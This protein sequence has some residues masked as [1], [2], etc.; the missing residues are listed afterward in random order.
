MCLYKDLFPCLSGQ[1]KGVTII[2][3]KKFTPVCNIDVI[4]TRRDR[5]PF[6][7]RESRR[8]QAR[9]ITSRR[10][11]TQR[12]YDPTREPS[13][14]RSYRHCFAIHAARL[15]KLYVWNNR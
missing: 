9:V 7:R 1:G 14:K 6:T 15:N 4:V 11:R 2:L 10:R 5:K 8:L 13:L 3:A 12:I